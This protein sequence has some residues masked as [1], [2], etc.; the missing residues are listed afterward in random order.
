MIKLHNNS[1]E[2]CSYVEVTFP[3]PATPARRL[4]LHSVMETKGQRL[5]HSD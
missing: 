2:K 5:R 3:L 1:I 4:K